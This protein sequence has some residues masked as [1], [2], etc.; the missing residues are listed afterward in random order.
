MQH[1]G[2][3]DIADMAVARLRGR[4]ASTN[5]HGSYAFHDE[6]DLTLSLGGYGGGTTMD[7][8]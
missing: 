1:N 8:N 7:S 6:D 2:H 4:Q 3:F 5:A